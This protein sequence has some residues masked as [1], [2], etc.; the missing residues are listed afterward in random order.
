MSWS[1]RFQRWLLGRRYKPVPLEE[2]KKFREAVHEGRNVAM[3]ALGSVRE[4]KRSSDKA[5][6]TAMRVI[7]RLEH[8]Q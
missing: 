8:E 4:A 6:D 5:Y 7:E 2:H 1:G 3:R